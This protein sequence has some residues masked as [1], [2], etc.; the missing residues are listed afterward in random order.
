METENQIL[1]QLSQPNK[2][3]SLYRKDPVGFLADFKEALALQPDSIVLAIWKERLDFNEEAKEKKIVKPNKD[4]LVMGCLAILAGVSTRILFWL[5]D[6]FDASP[7]NLLFGLIPFMAAFFLYKSKGGKGVLT[8]LITLFLLAG[9]YINLL[10]REGGDAVILAQLHLPIYLWIVAGIAFVGKD[11]KGGEAR[12]A[13]LKFNGEFAILYGAMAIGGMILTALTLNL[14]SIAG[15][16]IMN[17]YM[18]NIV[19]FGAAAVG[20]LAS[21]LILGPLKRAKNIT[22]VL[23]KLF[24]PL[25][26]GTLVSYLIVLLA[27]GKNPFVERDFLLAFNGMLLTIL[28]LTLFSITERQEGEKRT[29]SDYVS[30]ALLGLGV[31]IDLVALSAIVLR[32]SSY[33][34]TPNRIAVLGANLLILANLLWTLVTYLAFLRKKNSLQGIQKTITTYLPLYGLWAAFVVFIFP[35]IFS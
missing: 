33:G 23:A 2:L 35:W 10:P 11:L 8:L 34:V 12:L 20:V 3:E 7:V 22:P 5:V 4:F 13:F 9:V 30:V 19:L 31:M 26:L 16:D 24:S 15:V 18:N 27:A 28:A 25:V 17:I 1:N 6:K 21:Y 32:L 29:F 14:F